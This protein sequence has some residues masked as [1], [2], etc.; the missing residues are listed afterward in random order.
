MDTHTLM[1]DDDHI[2]ELCRNYLEGFIWTMSHYFKSCPSTNWYYRFE[3]GPSIR[4]LIDNISL[5]K[6]ISFGKEKEIGVIW[7]KLEETNKEFKLKTIL[8]KNEISFKENLIEFINWFSIYNLVPKG[9]VLKMFI[10][11]KS[12]F[13]KKI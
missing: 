2:E 3:G 9:M 10:G 11:D 1:I 7:D 13:K 8:E 6:K 5:V 4:T 12:F